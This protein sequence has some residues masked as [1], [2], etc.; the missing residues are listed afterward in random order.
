MLT[1]VDLKRLPDKDLTKL[2]ALPDIRINTP[3]L[4]KMYG[5]IREV[6]ALRQ[7]AE[8]ELEMLPVIDKLNDVEVL[9]D[10]KGWYISQQE[11]RN[12]IRELERY[13]NI[14]T[15]YDS[16]APS[17][18]DQLHMKTGISYRELSG[19]GAL[20]SEDQIL[21]KEL[22]ARQSFWGQQCNVLGKAV[23]VENRTDSVV[24]IGG[25]YRSF[26]SVSG[27]MS[28]R[29]LP[30]MSLPKL[31]YDFLQP[32]EGY[33][34][35]SLD[36]CQQEMRIA[37]ALTDCKIMQHELADGKD[38]YA[39]FGQQ[40]LSTE[41]TDECHRLGKALLT[42]Y[43]YGASEIT[44]KKNLHKFTNAFD[45][46][47]IQ[48]KIRTAYPELSEG[49]GSY[50]KNSFIRVTPYGNAPVFYEFSKPQLRNLPIQGLGAVIL[51]RL[52]LKLCIPGVKVLIPRHDEVIL[53]LPRT[54]DDAKVTKILAD[55]ALQVVEQE[56]PDYVMTNFVKIERKGE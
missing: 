39:E 38:V 20:F 1:I 42:P 7:L 24:S 4:E 55:T 45:D 13:F 8:L 53:E 50:A 46:V 36:F 28:C 12:R 37:S 49:L 10:L 25:K 41:S 16:G 17:L 44:L 48:M 56:L 54:L 31:M 21:A 33:S 43:L 27:R 11:L 6:P 34:I 30:L 19:N 32:S 3:L 40:F 35:W 26:S 18:V 52:L 9:F 29:D 23:F 47:D 2:C 15:A 5:I 14:D 51:K 22:F